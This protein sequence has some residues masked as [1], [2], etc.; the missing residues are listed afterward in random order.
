MHLKIVETV[1]KKI[2]SEKVR[3]KASRSEFTRYIGYNLPLIGP[4]LSAYR[5][6]I[7]NRYRYT[8]NCYR[9]L[10]TFIFLEKPRSRYRELFYGTLINF[11]CYFATRAASQNN[12]YVDVVTNPPGR[13]ARRTWAGESF[14]AMVKR[15]S[16]TIY[17]DR[18]R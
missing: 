8:V 3:F 12:T 18:S 11:K 13:R 1:S 4:T 9:A 16:E 7:P 5:C 17:R 15:K 6:D 14:S 10:V 2:S